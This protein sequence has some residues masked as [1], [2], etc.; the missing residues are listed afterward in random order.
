MDEPSYNTGPEGRDAFER[1]ALPEHDASALREDLVKEY[2]AVVDVVGAFD[3][4][5]MKGVRLRWSDV[6]S[7]VM[8]AG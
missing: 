4:R 3:G 5:V 8:A 7:G 1:V 2:F 6:P